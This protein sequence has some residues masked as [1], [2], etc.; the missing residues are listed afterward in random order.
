VYLLACTWL[1][2]QDRHKIRSVSVY[3]ARHGV[4]TSWG[5]PTFA[6]TLLGGTGRADRGA[7]AAFFRLAQ[8]VI[9]EED[10][11]PP[12]EWT[13]REKTAPRPAYFARPA[14]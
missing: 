14:P 8:R 9:S 13:P 3:L 7:R 1:D 10:A 4:A 2:T 11:S 5:A 12:G 6:D